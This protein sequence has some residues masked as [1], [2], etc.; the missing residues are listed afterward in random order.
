MNSTLCHGLKQL[1]TQKPQTSSTHTDTNTH[2]RMIYWLLIYYA[3]FSNFA[4]GKFA[5]RGKSI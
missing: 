3:I 1:N 4:V 5:P 2:C